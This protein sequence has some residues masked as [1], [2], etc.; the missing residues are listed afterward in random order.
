[1]N[2]LE[3]AH[4]SCPYCGAMLVCEIDTSVPVQSYTE[5]CHVC[6]APIVFSVVVDYDNDQMT[7]DVAREE[8]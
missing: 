5:D 8:E 1:M 4:V 6:C 2:P 7:V 3:A